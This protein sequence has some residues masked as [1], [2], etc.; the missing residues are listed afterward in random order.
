[1]FV[2]ILAACFWVGGMLFMVLVSSP[3]VRKTPFKDEAFQQIGTRFSKFGT[4][5][6]LPVLFISGLLNMHF[7]GVPY[8]AIIHPQN[9]YERTLQ[10]KIH[11]FLLIVIISLIHD[12]YF[13]KKAF[14]SKKHAKITRFLGILNLILSIC[15]ILFA[16]MLRYGL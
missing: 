16:S 10:I 2:H 12:F 11:T 1:M 13:G 14:Y 5:V 8:D 3:Y 4:L 9:I 7:L 6:S 15:I